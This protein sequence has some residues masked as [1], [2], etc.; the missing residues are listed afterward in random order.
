MV[1]AKMIGSLALF[2]PLLATRSTD[3]QATLGVLF[4]FTSYV[5]PGW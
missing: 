3:L 4:D 2:H 1:L 5:H